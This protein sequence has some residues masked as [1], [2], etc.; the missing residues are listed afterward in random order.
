MLIKEYR[1][2]STRVWCD[3]EK[4][5]IKNFVGPKYVP[6]NIDHLFGEGEYH[7]IFKAKYVE[8]RTK[9]TN[10]FELVSGYIPKRI[11]DDL[12]PPVDEVEEDYQ[13][14]FK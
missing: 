1:Q 3:G 10:E 7:Q 14:W 6:A 12:G 9:A 2:G 5:V 4:I 13:G 11:L 8:R